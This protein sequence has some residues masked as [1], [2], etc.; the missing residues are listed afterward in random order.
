MKFSKLWA[1]AF[2]L[3]LALTTACS[4]EDAPKPG[5]EVVDSDQIRYVSVAISAL[6]DNMS[7][8]IGGPDYDYDGTG[9][10][11]FDP[12]TEAENK[13]NQ[14]YFVF[15]NE[16]GEY[17]YGK[18]VTGSEAEDNKPDNT[19]YIFEGTVPV[20]VAEGQSLPTQMLVFLNPVD[21]NRLN[22]SI[23]ELEVEARDTYR[24]N[25]GNFSMSSS[26]YFAE[27]G[28][29]M[30]AVS[31]EG[32]YFDSEDEAK[33]AL[34]NT[35]D[36][37]IMDKVVIAHVERYC[38]KV[39]LTFSN[40]TYESSIG[41][42]NTNSEDQSVYTLKFYPQGWAVN[43][44]DK[45]VFVNKSWRAPAPSGSYLGDNSTYEDINKA[46]S[47]ERG[48]SGWK[49]NDPE[50]YRCFWGRS[51][52]YYD[53]NFPSVSADVNS[54]EW[55]VTYLSYNQATNAVPAANGTNSIYCTEST[56]SKDAINGATNKA[57]TMASLMVKGQYKLVKDGAEVDGFQTFYTIPTGS[58]NDIYFDWVRD[59]ANAGQSL[60]AGAT[61]I[62][63]HYA[64]VN[65]S[66]LIA[67]RETAA[68]GSTSIV[69][70]NLSDATPESLAALFTVTRPSNGALTEEGSSE[71][72][73]L[74]SR[75]VMLQMLNA[76]TSE[77]TG[78]VG[79][80]Q[81]QGYIVKLNEGGQGVL[82]CNY[83]T[84]GTPRVV[85]TAD[86][87]SN[88]VPAGQ[89]DWYIAR[90]DVNKLLFQQY[91]ATAADQYTNGMVYYYMPIYHLG[92]YAGENPNR[93]WN[94]DLDSLKWD[95][96]RVGDFGL[97]RNH[98]YNLSVGKINGL[99]VAVREPNDPIVPPQDVKTQALAYRI[100][101]LNW[102]VVPTQN[103]QW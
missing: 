18:M 54:A 43:A 31:V 96:V 87:I 74:A 80:T 21:Y 86:E 73:K 11:N 56:V 41:V 98:S 42:N 83:G 26:A 67:Y 100:R 51:P 64:D 10:P 9:D 23:L 52:S 63:Q 19:K 93:N 14:A 95:D 28:T 37:A 66:L 62:L 7:R 85:T 5:N 20:E 33:A 12:G 79:G 102:A 81:V 35:S 15:F 92:W 58:T 65:Y 3:P 48:G 46:L 76:P 91:R 13:V 70:K 24:N 16:A 88:N 36:Q 49:W 99:G 32:K 84:S 8:A 75:K 50:R 44:T 27:D 29:L 6:N 94:G 2:A 103:I 53:L 68:D 82:M 34:A 57:A 4:S 40:E 59:G 38:A 47:T 77:I 89:K 101:I 39:S 90:G 60:V 30:R 61:S 72:S 71:P 97:V 25:N 22:K 45:H 1:A 17:M 69:Y 55:P 78:W